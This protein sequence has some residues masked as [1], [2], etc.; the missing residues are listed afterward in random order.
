M[1]DAHRPPSQAAQDSQA[2]PREPHPP[3][4]TSP[5]VIVINPMSAGGE[6]RRRWPEVEGALRDALGEFRP[7][8]TERGGHA[9]ELARTALR[10]GARLVVAVGGDGTLN[11]V[12]NGFFEGDRPVAPEA[13]LG[14]LPLATGG[15]CIKTLGTSR[16]LAEAAHTLAHGTPR[17]IDLGRLQYIQ[18]DGTPATR[19][20]INIT[21]FGIG[22]LVDRYVNQSHK[23]LSGKASFFLATVRAS[24]TYKNARCRIALDDGPV[25]QQPIYIVAV[26]NGRFFGGGMKIAPDAEMDD[27]QFDVVTIGDVSMMTMMRHSS[28]IYRGTHIGLPHVSMQRARKVVAEPVDTGDEVLLDVDGEAPGRLPATFELLPRAIRIQV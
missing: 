16:K 10:E 7:L 2:P 17:T 24:L 18:H 12:V 28:K 23:L 6:T 14:I 27:G 20:F 9:T 19:Y 26:S 15:D 4:G 8:F 1:R 5:P 13:V 3:T 21:S 11:E 25:I 22:G